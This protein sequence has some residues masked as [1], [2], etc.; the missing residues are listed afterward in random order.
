MIQH[1]N[2]HEITR[3]NP[4]EPEAPSHSFPRTALF[5]IAA[6]NNPFSFSFFPF[7]LLFGVPSPASLSIASFSIAL[8]ASLNSRILCLANSPCRL[9]SAAERSRGSWM[10]ALKVS[11]TFWMGVLCRSAMAAKGRE[12]WHVSAMSTTLGSK[13]RG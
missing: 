7:F 2:A 1:S 12:A 8:R 10:I 9:L 11:N 3:T 6:F 4:H 13:T 5:K